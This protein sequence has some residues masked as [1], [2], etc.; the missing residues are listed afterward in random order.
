[1]MP[2]Q[3]KYSFRGGKYPLV[4][5]G[6][7]SCYG[8]SIGEYHTF[9]MGGKP[10]SHFTIRKT[11]TITALGDYLDCKYDP[12]AQVVF[13]AVMYDN[14]QCVV[15]VDL[16]G[17][18]GRLVESYNRLYCATI[19]ENLPV[20]VEISDSMIIAS[21]GE[22]QAL[23]NQIIET[24]EAFIIKGYKYEELIV[25]R[26]GKKKL[27]GVVI[28]EQASK[29]LSMVEMSLAE[30]SELVEEEMDSAILSTPTHRF[31]ELS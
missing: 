24:P 6:R 26:P 7:V 9:I 8:D 27:S 11:K 30:S 29:K 13:I 20:Q 16:L 17:E 28:A 22:D 1:M 10:Y 31:E 14:H 2:T 23:I 25:Y 4:A 3:Q 15:A 5:S 21:L 19:Q 12:L 18:S